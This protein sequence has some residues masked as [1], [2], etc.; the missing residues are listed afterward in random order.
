MAKRYRYNRIKINRS[1]EINDA[2][3]AADVTPQTIRV[4][5]KRGLPYLDDKRPAMIRGED[6]RDF[7]KNLSSR[8][9]PPLAL[10]EFRCAKCQA[11][12]MPYGMMADYFPHN[13]KSG[14]LAA[15]CPV[16]DTP[17]SLFYKASKLPEL[18]KVLEIAV[19]QVNED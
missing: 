17:L 19:R 13:E 4:W 9:A 12:R 16:C 10:G 2:A 14:R 6:L 18:S 15:I 3:K 11:R 7:V 1:Y 8:K 5:H